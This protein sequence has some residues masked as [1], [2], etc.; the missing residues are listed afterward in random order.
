MEQILKTKEI[1]LL[2]FPFSDQTGSKRRPALIISNDEF[3]KRSEDIIICAITSNRDTEYGITIK[4]EDWKDGLYSESYIK[5]DNL[6]TI[7]K[8]LIIKRIGRLST[9]R[10]NEV[11][12]KIRGL[13]G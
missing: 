10:F 8:S 11:I 7:D 2:P 6:L 9:E 1:V 5:P 4:S 3:N 13:I 12:L